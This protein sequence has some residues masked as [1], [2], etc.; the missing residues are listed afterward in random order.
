MT[1]LFYYMRQQITDYMSLHL[2]LH[3]LHIQLQAD[4]YIRYIIY[5]TNLHGTLHA[6]YMYFSQNYMIN[7]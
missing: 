2:S 3:A 5:Y 6:I 4:Y 7:K 1:S